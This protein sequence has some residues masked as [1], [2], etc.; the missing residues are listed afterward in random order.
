[1][2]D[3]SRFEMEGTV[4]DIIRGGKFIVELEN[5]H[6]CTCTLSGK[7]RTN[8]IKIIRGDS[9]RVDISTADPKL[10]NGRIIWRNK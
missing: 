4:V 7:L 8:Y 6:M 3:A 10:E 5:G 2:A 9:V 1:M